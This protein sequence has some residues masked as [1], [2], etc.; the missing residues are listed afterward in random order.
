MDDG[1]PIRLHVQINL[2][3]VSVKGSG[4]GSGLWGVTSC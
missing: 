3:Q 2:S 1:S 4:E